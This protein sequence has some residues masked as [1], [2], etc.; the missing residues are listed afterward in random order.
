MK[1]KKMIHPQKQN[2]TLYGKKEIKKGYMQKYKV[3][4]LKNRCPQL[5]E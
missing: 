4:Y 1:R 5:K 3:R 2:E